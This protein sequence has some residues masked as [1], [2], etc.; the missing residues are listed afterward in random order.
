MGE[1]YAGF[2]PLRGCPD[3]R[4]T[5]SLDDCYAWNESGP[6]SRPTRSGR[7]WGYLERTR[8]VRLSWSEGT[9]PRSFICRRSSATALAI[10]SGFVRSARRPS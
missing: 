9:R 8:P 3:V 7:A 6:L 4:L 5:A 2:Q 1:F 10:S